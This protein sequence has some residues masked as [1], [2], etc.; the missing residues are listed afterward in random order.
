MSTLLIRADASASIGTGHVMRC[1]ALAHAWQAKGGQVVFVTACSVEKL[2]AR[3]QQQ[4]TVH[5]I[6]GLPGSSED[7]TQTRRFIADTNAVAV[8]IDGYVFDEDYL[9]LIRSSDIPIL[10]LDD[11][12][13]LQHYTTDFVLNQNLSASKDLYHNREKTTR[14]LLGTQYVLLRPEFLAWQEW[15]R[16]IPPIAQNIL[17]TL[18]GSDPE[19]VVTKVIEALKLL[20][21]NATSCIIVGGGYENHAALLPLLT[22]SMQL[23]VNVDDMSKWM[24]WADIAVASASSVSWELAYMHLPAL[25]II[26]A[27]NQYVLASHLQDNAIAQNMGWYHRLSPNALAEAIQALTLDA[28]RRTTLSRNGRRIVDGMGAA[29]V[30]DALLTWS[31]EYNDNPY[32]NH[33][34]A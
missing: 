21:I 2:L 13:Q 28:D 11:Y 17:V 33:T 25:S 19:N 10:L 34:G 8:V 20:N 31:K 3:I 29:R 27:E 18:G 23:Q 32:F 22:D 7:A 16:H 1:I 14:L 15:Q 24:A 6:T 9:K 5:K 12:G 26:L 30:V 4:G